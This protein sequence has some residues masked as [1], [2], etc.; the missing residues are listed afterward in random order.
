MTRAWKFHQSKRHLSPNLD[1][2]HG[3]RGPWRSR[4]GIREFSWIGHSARE[5]GYALH[6][7][8]HVPERVQKLMVHQ[9][10]HRVNGRFARAGW[11]NYPLRWIALHFRPK[12][13][14]YWLEHS[15]RRVDTADWTMF[16]GYL[17]HF[18]ADSAQDLNLPSR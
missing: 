16:Y 7:A 18:V 17:R 9:S 6:I 14:S 8:A 13:R 5:R 12:F 1:A 2:R 3:R 11:S 15:P 10:R 4:W